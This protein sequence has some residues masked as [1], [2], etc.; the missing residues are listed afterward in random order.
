MFFS[1]DAA[2]YSAAAITRD[3]LSSTIGN[4]CS[5]QQAAAAAAAAG[6][7]RCTMIELRSDYFHPP[8]AKFSPRGQDW[9]QDGQIK[10]RSQ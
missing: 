9:R 10:N 2:V 4:N 6:E 7:R 3:V 1:A 5:S 8:C